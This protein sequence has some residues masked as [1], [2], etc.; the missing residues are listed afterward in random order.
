[1]KDGSVSCPL[2]KPVAVPPQHRTFSAKDLTEGTESVVSH[3]PF[4]L[5]ASPINSFLG[6]N[7]TTAR[8]KPDSPGKTSIP[9]SA[10][11]AVPSVHFQSLRYS[12]LAPSCLF[13]SRH[14]FPSRHLV[15]S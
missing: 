12:L 7:L 8:Q 5:L 1:M 14:R 4:D 13:T 10:Y 11:Y 3:I 6:M 9:R 15:P 2:G